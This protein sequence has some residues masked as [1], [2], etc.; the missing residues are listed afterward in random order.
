MHQPQSE[1]L[2]P[3]M[4]C[5]DWPDWWLLGSKSFLARVTLQWFAGKRYLVV[6]RKVLGK[7]IG[8]E[9]GAP[10]IVHLIVFPGACFASSLRFF[11]ASSL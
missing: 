7:A 1:G 10:N 4:G 2:A 6:P 3:V 5:Y 9:K 8:G 11:S